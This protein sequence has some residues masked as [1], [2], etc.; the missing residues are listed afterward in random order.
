MESPTACDLA[1]MTPDDAPPRRLWYNVFPMCNDSNIVRICPATRTFDIPWREI[2]DHSELL[3]LLARRDISVIY[4]Q[5][6]LGPI[7]FLLQPVLTAMVFSVVFGRI[8]KIST[9]GMPRVL[10]Y[11][12]GLVVWNYFR[13]VMDGV[14]MSFIHAKSLFAKVYFPRLLVPLSFPISHLVFFGLNLAVFFIFYAYNVLVKG[15]ALRPN[16]WLCA[17]PLVVVWI[18][19]AA[20]GFGLIVA[21]FTT[22]YRDLRF[23]MPFIFQV[24]MFSSPIIYPLNGVQDPFFLTVMHLNPVGVAVEALRY[25]LTGCGL[26]TLDAVATGAIV[27]ACALVLGL[28]AFNKAQRNF[29]DTI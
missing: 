11:L 5:T 6:I 15:F 1:S 9:Y 12:N 27:I 19:A 10:F 25:M 24:W 20:T 2:F 7:W 21:A 28:G 26:V 16:W 23:A 22:K 17:L 29:V 14:S 4:K 13:G 18:A 3:L 8:A